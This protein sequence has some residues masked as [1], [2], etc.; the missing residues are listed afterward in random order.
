MAEETI[1]NESL[2]DSQDEEIDDIDQS[3][4]AEEGNASDES[5]PRKVH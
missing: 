1:P 4:D 3:S 5:K 2:D